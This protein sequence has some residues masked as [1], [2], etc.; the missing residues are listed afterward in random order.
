MVQRYN[1]FEK[2]ME[3]KK[4]ELTKRWVVLTFKYEERDKIGLFS[5][6]ME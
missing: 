3:N 1:C 5:I 2:W 4:G 6:R